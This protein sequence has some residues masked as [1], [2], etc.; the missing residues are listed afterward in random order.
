M[1]GAATL[2][3]GALSNT[4]Y[5][6][7]EKTAVQVEANYTPVTLHEP[8]GETLE[9]KID[10]IASEYNISPKTL[11]NLVKSES[12]FNPKARGTSGE[13]GLVQIMPSWGFTVEQMEDPDFALTF[14]AK[15]ISEGK[16]WM[17]TV[18]S[19]KSYVKAR[20]AKMPKG[21]ANDIFP[22]TELPRVGGVVILKY[23]N[24]DRHHLAYIEKIT[25][26]GLHIAESNYTRCL[27]SRRIIPLESK[28]IMGYWQSWL[29]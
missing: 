5:Y 7:A 6:V 17:W 3:S 13:V 18:C 27:V 19:C 9:Q 10:R 12:N 1:L 26:E 21:D 23:W 2:V 29:D 8:L 16:E 24:P 15:K 22:N 28:N 20:G 25:S 11:Y 14:A 4:T